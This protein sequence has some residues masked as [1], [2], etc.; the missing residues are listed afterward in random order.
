MPTLTELD[1]GALRIGQT[2]RVQLSDTS[3]LEVRFILFTVK[4]DWEETEVDGN[5]R[6]RNCGLFRIWV[7]RFDVRT[8]AHVRVQPIYTTKH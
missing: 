2:V 1:V 7:Q 4:G 5:E 8:H 3:W 6:F